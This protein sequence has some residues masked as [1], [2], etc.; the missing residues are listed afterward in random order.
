M[1]IRNYKDPKI[2]GYLFTMTLSLGYS[3]FDL[4]FVV[5]GENG[6]AKGHAS[7]DNV[8]IFFRQA[9]YAFTRLSF[10]QVVEFFVAA[11]YLV[12]PDMQVKL[13]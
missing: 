6:S 8:D 7:H 5:G 4:S 1:K 13:F 11:Q 2:S 12:L 3:D 10:L 9:K